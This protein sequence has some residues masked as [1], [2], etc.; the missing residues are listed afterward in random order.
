MAGLKTF[1]G[2]LSPLLG[3]TPAALY[4]RQRVLV[5][6]GLIKTRG[7]RGPG[8]GVAFTAENL[9]AL[10]ISILATDSLSEID[11][12]VVDLCN[13]QPELA[14]DRQSRTHQTW[15]KKGKPTFLTEV[16]RVLS[17]Q[18]MLWR[19]STPGIIRVTRMWRAQIL[20]EIYQPLLIKQLTFLPPHWERVA[21]SALPI[22]LTAE[23]G[24]E[25]LYGLIGFFSHTEEAL[26]A[27]ASQDQE[28]PE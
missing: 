9:A 25:A 26:K 10:V 23:I 28:E 7:G 3:V 18:P 14:L 5:D 24:I 21:E 13:A 19:P 12:R 4:E 16:A 1:L 20:P 6:I 8:S 15:V 2:R 17:R 11:Q 22:S 27:A